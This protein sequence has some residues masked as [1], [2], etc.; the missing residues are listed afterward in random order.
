[1]RLIRCVVVLCLPYSH[2]RNK[3]DA[4]MINITAAKDNINRSIER[5][6]AKISSG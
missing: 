4:K 2:C 6:V 1:M 5:D 3:N